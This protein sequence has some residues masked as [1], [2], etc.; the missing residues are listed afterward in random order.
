[1]SRYKSVGAVALTAILVGCG[2]PDPVRD[3]AK[4]TA[5]NTAQL[6]AQVKE[7]TTRQTAIAEIRAENIMSAEHRQGMYRADRA[8][9]A[10]VLEASGNTNPATLFEKLKRLSE[11]RKAQVDAERT[12]E[13]QLAKNLADA[14]AKFTLPSEEL[15]ATAKLLGQLAED[16]DAGDRVKFIVQFAKSVKKDVDNAKKAAEK[17]KKAGS[18]AEPKAAN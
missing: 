12:A 18:D 1:M 16:M 11:V 6:E 2:T 9:D 17:D 5:A 13:K 4:L 15:S 14:R 3:L 7:F 8:V 10:A